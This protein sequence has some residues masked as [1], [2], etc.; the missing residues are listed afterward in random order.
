[1]LYLLLFAPC[2]FTIAHYYFYPPTF[3]NEQIHCT[4]HCFA[5][6]ADN[7]RFCP[8]IGFCNS[9][10][11]L[12]DLPEV[13]AADSELKAFQTQ[14]TK[15]GQDMVKALQDKAAELERKKDSRP[16]L[17]QRPG[18]ATGCPAG[19]TGNH[20]QLRAG[21]LYQAL[22]E[23]RETL[24]KPLLDRVNLAMSEVAKANSFAMVFDASTQVLLFA[25]ESLDVTKLVQAK[26][27]G[28]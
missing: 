2:L 13:K 20:R 6:D 18:D 16:D 23:K 8:E 24:Y 5:A 4:D 3:N 9:S 1:M 10:S 17:A 12:A 27:S 26:L 21:S 19:G 15:K 25:D 7:G 14:L 22:S 11:L 28:K